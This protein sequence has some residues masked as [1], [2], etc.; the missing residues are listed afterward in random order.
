MTMTIS[1][2]SSQKKIGF[3]GLGLI[4]G[5]IAKA[6]RLYYPDYQL[7]A[8]DKNKEALVLAMQ[9]GT[10]NVVCSAIDQNFQNCQYIFLCAPIAYNAAYLH[11]LKNTI[12]DKCIITDVGSVKTSIHEE[13]TKL[14]LGSQFIGG[15]PMAGSEKSGYANAKAHLIE[16]AYYI[17]TP[18]SQIDTT[19]VEELR[20]F[21]GSLHAIPLIL[22]YAE[23]DYITGA[24]SHLPHILASCLVNYVHKADNSE[25]LM[26]R[27]AA[28]GF[29]DITRIASSSP[30]MWQQI[31]LKNKKNI[32]YILEEYIQTL[33]HAKE[34]IDSECE[35]ELF[36]LFED[37][38]EYRNS[39]PDNSSGP[40]KK[41]F[42]LYCDII[43]EAGG[44]AT[45]AT[46]LASNMISIKNIGIIHNREF[47]EGVLRIE[48]YDEEA[49]TKAT[50]LLKKYRYIVYER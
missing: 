30:I 46:I 15:H 20:D 38:R 10:I 33:Q 1:S 16:N 19:L 11:Q 31:C 18:S 49:S 5:S 43:D 48:F 40:I 27:L 41:Q 9:D 23:H 28:G 36:S 21:I 39:M 6:I 24:I 25:E 35:A 34:A 7:I 32:S 42:A 37:S 29:K 4:G 50:E 2:P 47:E 44:I 13:V 22:D 12:S 8:F 45:I 14:Q 3:I 26:K 17:L